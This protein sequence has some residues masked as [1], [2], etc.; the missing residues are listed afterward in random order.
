MFRLRASRLAEEGNVCSFGIVTPLLAAGLTELTAGGI[1]GGLAT[2]IA[3]GLT[4]AATGAG[5]GAIT[6]EVTGGKPGQGALF[7]GLTGGAIGGLGPALGSEIGSAT[8]L[9]PGVATAAGDIAAGAGAGVI[10]GAITGQNPL[11][12]GLEGGA[13]G[14]VS[15]VL[16]G[17]SSGPAG[18]TG[19]A[20][21]SPSAGSTGGAGGAAAPG[22]VALPTAAGGS[23]PVDPTQAIGLSGTTPGAGITD[24]S[25]FSVGANAGTGLPPG[26]GTLAAATPGGGFNLDS[27]L[28][29]IGANPG[30]LLAG[31]ALGLDLLKGNQPLPGQTAV[32]NQATSEASAG[33]TL[34]AY[35]QSGTLPA[36]LQQIVNSNTEAGISAVRAN[37]ANLGLSGSTMEAQAIAQVKQAASAQTAQ[38][39]NQ[40]FSQGVA[41]TG[42]ANSEFNTLLETQLKQEQG[43]Q[44]AIASF[45][46]ALGGA[47]NRTTTS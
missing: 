14:A 9:S 16:G 28:G 44:T 15:G 21:V 20:A 5:L 3:G 12:S 24:T 39:A 25:L 40:L 43:L 41:M 42:M 4:G 31:G 19:T 17:P 13:A 22:A 38:I 33:A 7:G 27:I 1:A 45:A 37:F 32:Q 46:G 34:E 6:S 23:V 47:R 30:I 10:G 2:G 8:G 35:Q 11:T 36:G 29:K 18:A 26:V